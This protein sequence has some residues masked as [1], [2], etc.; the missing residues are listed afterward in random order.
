MKSGMYRVYKS[1]YILKTDN[2][3]KLGSEN[4]FGTKLPYDDVEK[5]ID[6]IQKDITSIGY[7]NFKF[8]FSVGNSSTFQIGDKLYNFNERE[9]TITDVKIDEVMT[10]NPEDKFIHYTRSIS[11]ILEYLSNIK[12]KLQYC[13]SIT[14]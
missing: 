7:S 11:P 10:Q 1:L 12:N 14:Q 13:K 2:F 9:L 3:L 8:V 6:D 4:Y 5:I